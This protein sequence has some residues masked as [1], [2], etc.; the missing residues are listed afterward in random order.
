VKPVL[1]ALERGESL[2]F[3]NLREAFR[4]LDADPDVRR[5]TVASY[6]GQHEHVS[7]QHM[8]LPALW[9]AAVGE[10]L[11]SGLESLFHALV[12]FGLDYRRFL[13][14]VRDAFPELARHDRGGGRRRPG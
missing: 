1:A 6:D 14:E 12:T 4:L 8:A 10:P 9:A 11:G 7:R 2:L 13:S 3:A 5:T